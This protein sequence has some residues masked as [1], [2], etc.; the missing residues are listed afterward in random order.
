MAEP[1]VFVSSVIDG[2]QPYR[3]AARKGIKAAGGEPV[4]VNEDFP[5]LPKSSRNA[6]LDAV[7]SSDIYLAI[8]G[9]RAG[10]RAPSGKLVVE[11][12]FEKAQN[13]DMPVLLFLVAGDREDEAE[14][15]ARRLSDYVEGYFRVEVES[16]TELQEE[17]ERALERLIDKPSDEQPDMQR[18]KDATSAPCDLGGRPSL[19]TVLMPEREE[20]VIDPMTLES[21]KFRHRVYRIAHALSVKLLRYK[22]QKSHSLSQNALV[23]TQ[24]SSSRQRRGKEDVRIEI[25]ER[26]RIIVDAS[27]TEPDQRGMGAGMV[28]DAS[29][30]K[31]VARRAYAF[32]EAFFDEIDQHGRYQ[33]FL[34]NAVL[35]NPGNRKIV[36]EVDPQQKTFSV[37]YGAQN[38][39]IVAFDT[40]RNISRNTL[41][42]PGGEIGRIL[43]RIRRKRESDTQKGF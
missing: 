29:K 39:H 15:L 22:E 25:G 4:L 23:I 3:E 43:T 36:D 11:E 31:G 38:D 42:E 12:E 16:P 7:A 8:I 2:F 13:R 28:I 32:A 41:R 27:V 20:E 1:R 10:W 40:P 24:R 21:D 34:H 17:T 9:E 18:V 30:I 19:R 5:S 26:G 37:P 6:C 35:A 33:Q 14:R